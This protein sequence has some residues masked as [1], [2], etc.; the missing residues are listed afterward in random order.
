MGRVDIFLIKYITRSRL[1]QKNFK[2]NSNRPENS[3]QKNIFSNVRHGAPT[4]SVIAK[5]LD[6][7]FWKFQANISSN[8]KLK[9]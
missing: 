6:D 9:V 5:T 3:A 1:S 7:M 2:V 8:L 4:G